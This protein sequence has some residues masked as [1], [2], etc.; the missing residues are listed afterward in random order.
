MTPKDAEVDAVARPAM[1][2]LGA[3]SWG[4]ALAVH[5]ARTGHSTVL[6][7]RDAAQMAAI[8]AAHCN[9]RYL[10][11]APFPASLVVESDLA[12]AV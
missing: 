2:V 1:A 5:L 7:G 11:M 6:W 10:P 3:G 4:T 9:T 8:A 12:R